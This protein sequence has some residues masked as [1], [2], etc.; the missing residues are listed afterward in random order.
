MSESCVS[1]GREGKLSQVE[2]IACLVSLV[3]AT[4]SVLFHR[5]E[6][7]LVQ[8]RWNKRYTYTLYLQT[9]NFIFTYRRY[10]YN[11]DVIS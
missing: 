7:V 5:F 1:S 9:V 8:V 10:S 3:F 4:S 2:R 6:K 11:C